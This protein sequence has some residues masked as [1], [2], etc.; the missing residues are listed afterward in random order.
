MIHLKKL[1]VGTESVESLVMWQDT[2]KVLYHG[3]DAVLRTTRNTP[4][5]E[6]ELVSGGS[7][8]WVINRRIQ[9]RQEIIAIEQDIDEGGRKFCKLFLDPEIFRTQILS[10]KP[11]QGWR[12]LRAEDAPKDIG[13]VQ[14]NQSQ[15]HLPPDEMAHDLRILGL[16]D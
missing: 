2:Q 8:Y 7:I 3:Y 13:P 16:I 15:D 5:Q 1:S 11:F 10:H 6:R 9:C 4:K 12:Y 14:L